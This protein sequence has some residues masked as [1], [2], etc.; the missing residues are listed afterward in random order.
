M[1]ARAYDL[2]KS[3]TIPVT[4]SM[5]FYD[6]TVE[7]GVGAAIVVNDEGWIITAAHNAE[8]VRVHFQH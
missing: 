5:R 8:P 4:V 2:A 3:F 1:F 6:G 7:C